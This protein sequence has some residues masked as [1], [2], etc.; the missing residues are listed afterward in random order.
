M[1]SPSLDLSGAL[2][3]AGITILCQYAFRTVAFFYRVLASIA[4]SFGVV[5]VIATFSGHEFQYFSR[6]NIRDFVIG[7]SSGLICYFALRFLWL[8]LRRA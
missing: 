5:I 7:L 8:R 1:I 6:E 2:L 4:I 3:Y